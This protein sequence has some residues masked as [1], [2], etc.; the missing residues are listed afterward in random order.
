MTRTRC[1]WCG[2]TA[3]CSTNGGWE[4]PSGHIEK[5]ED[6]IET[7]TREF[8]EE[9]GWTMTDGQLIWELARGSERWGS[10]GYLVVGRAGVQVGDT[11]PDAAAELAWWPRSELP[12]LVMGGLVTECFT[13]AALFW[14]S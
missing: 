5:G 11:D 6:P 7:A 10:R 3:P 9:T 1:A 4:L 2:A 14:W 8:R 12:G 13:A